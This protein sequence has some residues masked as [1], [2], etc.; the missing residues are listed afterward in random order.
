MDLTQFKGES[1]AFKYTGLSA[2]NLHL[3]WGPS[4]QIDRL[5]FTDMRTH[6]TMNAGASNTEINPTII[7]QNEQE[8]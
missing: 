3:L 7:K 6:A 8:L 2:T 4:V 5:N 1:T